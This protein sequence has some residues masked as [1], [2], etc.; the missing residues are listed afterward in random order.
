M[1]VT[2]IKK[3]L[4]SDNVDVRLSVIPQLQ[5]EGTQEA[6]DI[7]KK[8]YQNDPDKDVRQQAKAIG[9]I[10][11]ERLKAQKSEPFI[12]SDEI[13]SMYMGGSQEKPPAQVTRTESYSTNA[14][15]NQPTGNSYNLKYK[16]KMPAVYYKPPN[17]QQ[18]YV[19]LTVI[20]VMYFI[21]AILVAGGGFIYAST[22]FIAADQVR[23]GAQDLII[24]G[25]LILASTIV[26][27]ISML[28]MSNLINLLI[29][30][31]QNSRRTSLLLEES[32][33]TQIQMY[34]AFQ[35]NLEDK[36]S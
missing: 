16:K 26:T 22:I 33:K 24:F 13:V 25:F 34:K 20:S 17:M 29:D 19:S 5:E 11:H 21:A 27:F 10:V 6:L 9:L 3:A 18:K 32:I 15:Q 35:E 12:P 30:L 28:A 8:I 7:L 36:T 31:E 23:S 1:D 14:G 2:A 4:R